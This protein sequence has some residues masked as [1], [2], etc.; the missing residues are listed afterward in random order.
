M[1]RTITWLNVISHHFKVQWCQGVTSLWRVRKLLF[2]SKSSLMHTLTCHNVQYGES[3][4]LTH[5]GSYTDLTCWRPKLTL[6]YST[7]L[8]NHTIFRLLLSTKNIGHNSNLG[9]S[10]YKFWYS[11]DLLASPP[12]NTAQTD[13]DFSAATNTAKNYF[14]RANTTSTPGQSKKDS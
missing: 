10:T 14:F 11:S 1:N 2:L 5:M 9:K 13:F 8:T 12:E 4:F 7:R 3:C 6:S